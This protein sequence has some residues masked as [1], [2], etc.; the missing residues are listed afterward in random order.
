LGKGLILTVIVIVILSV[1]ALAYTGYFSSFL[2]PKPAVDMN[3]KIQDELSTNSI[4]NTDWTVWS[5]T[6]R[7]SGGILTKMDNWEQ[8]KESYKQSPWVIVIMLDQ[9]ARVV[10]F[11]GA[12]NQA[13]YYEY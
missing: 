2:E 13:T 7:D 8:F 3:Q 5:R 4:S 12:M 11:K 6:F 10:W 9:N 1:S